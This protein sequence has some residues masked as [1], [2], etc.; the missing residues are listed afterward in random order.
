L[1]SPVVIARR[2]MR[3]GMKIE[4]ALDPSTAL[5]AGESRVLK[6]LEL[7]ARSVVVLIAAGHVIEDDVRIDLETV[8]V[9][10]GDQTE[11]SILVAKPGAGVPFLFF[12]PEV[13]MVEQVIPHPAASRSPFARGRDPDS[14][15]AHVLQSR[16]ELREI[17]VPAAG[18]VA[19]R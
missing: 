8:G 19:R 9:G 16:R 1:F 5:L 17:S 10:H 7:V 18:A 13:V 15:E 3:I 2:M 11:E 12:L 6:T 14:V 4:P